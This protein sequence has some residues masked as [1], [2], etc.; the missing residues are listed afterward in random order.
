MAVRVAVF[1][2]NDFDKVNGV[3]TTLKAVLQFSE[4]AAPRVYTASDLGAESDRYLAVSARG[5]GLPWYREMR[6]YWPPL[7]TFARALRRDRIQVV[8]VTTPGPVGLAG[9][10]LAERLRL[11]LVGSY[12]T[13]LGDYA[14][15][16]SGSRRLG[17]VLERYMR[18]CYAPCDPILVPSEAAREV[19]AS[20]GYVR[21]RL[22]IWS[23]GVD[24]T[25]FSPE[26]A[27]AELRRAW[28]ADDRRPAI[29]YAGRLSR[30]KGLDLVGPLQR[31]LARRG[32]AHQ[33][34]FAGDGPMRSELEA[35]CPDGVFLGS[36]SHDRVAVA[37][38]SSDLLFFP[39]TTDTLGNVVLEAQA[40]GLPVVVSDVG[41]PQQQMIRRAT[42]VVC[43]AGD[44]AAFANA[45]AMLLRTPDRRREMG[46]QAR[47][48]AETRGWPRALAP[49]TAAWRAAAARAAAA[50]TGAAS[51]AG[52]LVASPRQNSR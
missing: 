11:P 23:R 31:E 30:E 7:R 42:G 46:R 15:T 48:Y 39:S 37:M 20:R 33:F 28:R 40:S 8:H 45:L 29:L 2:D 10:W 38:A 35:V 21:E 24:V 43:R 6:I 14:A 50:Y 34:V 5:V 13:H 9:R 36:L 16:F 44:V 49:L 47:R 26:R 22:Q 52:V 32:V 19:L 41:G 1:T 18:W 27:S 12:H 25:R 3:T 51:S 17:G 4:C